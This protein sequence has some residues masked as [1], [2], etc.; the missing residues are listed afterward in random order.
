MAAFSALGKLTILALAVWVL[1]LVYISGVL[2]KMQATPGGGS[3]GSGVAAEAL[4]R[5][6]QATKDIERLRKQN[7]DLK[8]L[9]VES[10]RN[11]ADNL[12]ADKDPSKHDSLLG[13]PK[14]IPRLGEK[15][16]DILGKIQPAGAVY[17]VAHLSPQHDQLRRKVENGVL[18]LFFHYSSQL[19]RL[20]KTARDAGP[21]NIPETEKAFKNAIDSTSAHFYALMA[22]AQKLG[23]VDGAGTLRD[24]RLQN[25][26]N[27]MQKRIKALQNPPDCAN[28]RKLLCNLNKGC[29][30]G[31]QLHH[32]AYC[33]VIAYGTERTLILQNDGREW[34]YSSQ[35]WTAAFLP[36]SDSCFD[37]PASANPWIS[38]EGNKNH[39]VVS[40]PIVDGLSGRPPYLPQS[41]PKDLADDLV[42]LHGDPPAWFIGQF[43]SYLMRSSPKLEKWL[44]EAESRIRFGEGK[45]SVLIVVIAKAATRK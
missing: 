4:Q 44:G 15:P 7:E 33:F 36:V 35:G 3:E 30:F 12:A 17:Q 5:I 41:F 25:L 6:D 13:H 27:L 42:H 16:T 14:N 21:Q 40:L 29:G 23:E 39:Q 28:A 26:T 31:C 18:E 43:V 34:R 11:V 8:R 38:I 22:D 2:V 19:R 10:S 1:L 45:R 24:R 20:T 37:G 32:V 9:L